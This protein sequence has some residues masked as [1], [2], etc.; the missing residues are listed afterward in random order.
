MALSVGS[1]FQPLNDFFLAHF[2]TPEG[3]PIVF[4]FD[5]FG[6]TVSQ[7][8]FRSNPMDPNSA[9]SAA[10]AHEKVSDLVNR[11]PSDVGDGAHVVLLSDSIDSVYL[12]QLLRPA[13]PYLPAGTDQQTRKSIMD[14]FNAMKS[15]ALRLWENSE[16]TSVS[17]R[18]LGFRP[19]DASPGNWCDP[20][21]T[22]VWTAHSLTVTDT[23]SPVLQAPLIW[24]RA[25]S[26]QQLQLMLSS[27]VV[28]EAVPQGSLTATAMIRPP[29]P[30]RPRHDSHAPGGVAVHGLS[31][32]LELRHKMFAFDARQ[33]LRLQ[34]V[35]AERAPQQ[36][37]TTSTVNLS[38]EYCL[39][40]LRRSW[41]KA[42]FINASTWKIPGQE[43]GASNRAGAH[44]G[45]TQLPVGFVA[46]R[47][48]KIS[49]S[50]SDT[51]RANLT[52]AMSWGPFD[53]SSSAGASD[54]AQ[55]GLQIIG[56]LLQ[57]LPPLPPNPPVDGPAA[58][59]QG[60]LSL[61]T[62]TTRTYTVKQG[63][64]LRK[65]AQ[66]FYGDRSKFRRIQKANSLPDPNNIRVGQVLRIP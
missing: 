63:D 12:D 23:Q 25:P 40:S 42:T 29:A 54:V 27:S 62:S 59:G 52:N 41:L 36:P 3:S 50:W 28:G 39:V 35:L 60:G 9:F 1:I 44:G 43:Q 13:E 46:V 21:S 4:R 57:D 49:A 18:P 65:I 61:P 55:P 31:P 10:V 19:T 66:R 15:D 32:R 56:W 51:D 38:F 53:V 33:R 64:T 47:N 24:R 20:A 58:T 8:D 26:D 37:V 2:A 16:L 30:M 34:E 45:L 17:G 6:S 22:D 14:D 48:L 7:D 5:K 11:V